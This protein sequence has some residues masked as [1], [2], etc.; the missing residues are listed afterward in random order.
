VRFTVKGIAGA[1]LGGYANDKLKL[2]MNI[3][4]PVIH[5]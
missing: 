4:I 2:M 1:A 5:W 3:M